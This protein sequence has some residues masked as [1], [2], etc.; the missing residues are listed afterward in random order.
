MALRR[1]K[2]N[3]AN[4]AIKSPAATAIP[5]AKELDSDPVFASCGTNAEVLPAGV[6]DPD[7][8]TGALNVVGAVDQEAAA[9]VNPKEAPPEVSPKV[10]S[11]LDA[12][13]KFMTTQ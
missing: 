9:K 5:A 3:A 11:R 1:T 10:N 4:P 8:L 6:E 2:I 13:L 12:E 7:V